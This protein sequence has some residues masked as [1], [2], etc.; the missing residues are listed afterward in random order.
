[1]KSLIAVA[2][3]C[4]FTIPV[5][6]QNNTPPVELPRSPNP[7]ENISNDVQK[8]AKSVE[9]L[10]KRMRV[11]SETFTSNQGLRLTSKQQK[12]LLAFEPLNRAE[13][14]LAT[15]QKLKIDLLDKQAFINTKLGD[16]EINSSEENINR[17]VTLTGTT[18][19]EEIREN[20]RRTFGKERNDLTNLLNEIRSTLN[21]TNSE[22]RQTDDFVK[23]IRSKLFTES[24]QELADF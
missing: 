9:T 14:R 7:L 19:T 5:F 1:M 22:I 20:R 6:A 23:G 18:R 15:L 3:L 10:N 11:F 8:L 12:L 4:V 21:D 24:R 2:F 16:N 17:S 13:Q